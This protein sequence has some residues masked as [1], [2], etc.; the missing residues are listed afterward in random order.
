MPP[1][2]YLLKVV[3]GPLVRWDGGGLASQRRGAHRA[4]HGDC[5]HAAAGLPERRLPVVCA[6]ASLPWIDGL[7]LELIGDGQIVD[8]DTQ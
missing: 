2:S 6:R 8:A 5:S 3:S 7:E 1:K 4:G